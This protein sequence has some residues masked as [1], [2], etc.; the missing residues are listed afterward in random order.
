MGLTRC[1]SQIGLPLQSITD[2][3][4]QATEMCFFTALEAGKP[5]IK[6][7][8]NLISGEHSLLDLQ[9]A[10]F[11]T[12]PHMVRR[13]RALWYLLLIKVQTL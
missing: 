1:L 8:V 4:P 10:T 12:Y 11:S 3:G 13:D 6:V 9:S 7:L 2:S 5:K